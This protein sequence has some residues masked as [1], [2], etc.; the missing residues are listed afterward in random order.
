MREKGEHRREMPDTVRG[1]L[2]L[3]DSKRGNTG[4]ITFYDSKEDLDP[5]EAEWEQ[6]GNEIRRKSGAVERPSRPSRSPRTSFRRCEP[7]LTPGYTPGAPS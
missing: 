7:P 3:A 2:V 6:K 5:I 4:F 1:F